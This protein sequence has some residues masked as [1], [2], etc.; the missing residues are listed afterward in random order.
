MRIFA[1]GVGTLLLEL[2]IFERV[3]G[4]NW[5]AAAWIVL[6]AAFLLRKGVSAKT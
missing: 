4:L 3:T 6:I 5:T 2:V 1:L